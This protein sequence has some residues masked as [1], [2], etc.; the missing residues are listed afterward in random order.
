MKINFSSLLR[1]DLFLLIYWNICTNYGLKDAF[2]ESQKHALYGALH[3][4]QNY[5]FTYVNINSSEQQELHDE[6][7]RL[8]DVC[9]FLALLRLIEKK[10][11][12]AAIQLD[13]QIGLLIGKSNTFSFNTLL[14]VI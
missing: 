10:G 4:K 1:L 11:D 6:D 12:K 13:A 3:D 7:V 9:P 5:I 8:C 14:F 2:E